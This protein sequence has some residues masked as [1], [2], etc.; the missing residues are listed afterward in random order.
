MT[1]QRPELAVRTPNRAAGGFYRTST[2]AGGG[3]VFGG[4]PLQ[5]SEDAVVAAVRAGYRIADAQIE[6]GMRIAESLRGAAARSGAGDAKEVLTTT[7]GLA[8]R[9]AVLLLN[10]IDALAAQ[11]STVLKRILLSEPQILG[12]LIGLEPNAWGGLEKILGALLRQHG[13]AA[14]P[15]ADRASE[16][17]P[18]RPTIV[19]DREARPVE[20]AKW[21]L[22]HSVAGA[23]FKTLKFTRVGNPGA[24][25]SGNI[26]TNPGNGKLVLKL[27]LEAETPEGVWKA[28][29]CGPNNELLGIVVINL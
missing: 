11:P 21:Q 6:N 5:A 4:I 3:S 9:A 7:E 8:R 26:E 23:D 12:A 19:F 22:D 25:F 10:G 2:G 15:E 28:P 29:I 20:L 1:Y 17:E 14:A 24:T 27:A 16:P 18:V 13:T